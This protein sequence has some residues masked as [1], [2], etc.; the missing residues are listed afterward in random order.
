[1]AVLAPGLDQ[2]RCRWLH[3]GDPPGVRVGLA[4]RSRRAEAQGMSCRAHR[5][6]EP[7]PLRVPK[8]AVP[9]EV[10]TGGST[11][12]HVEVFLAPPA[13]PGGAGERLSDLLARPRFLPVQ[14]AG[15]VTFLNCQLPAWFRLPLLDGLEELAP[16]TEASADAVSWEVRV[17]LAPSGFLEGTLR[18]LLPAHACRLGDYLRH[19]PTF[20]PLRTPDWLYL[21]NRAC[22][23]QVIPNGEVHD[24]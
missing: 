15:V 18:Y 8:R 21:V 17:E 3:A 16:E 20:F 24:G 19:A 13:H 6:P 10:A 11:V 4:R 12:R 9:V 2:Q 23:V 22:V 7:S 14:E 5:L 1:M